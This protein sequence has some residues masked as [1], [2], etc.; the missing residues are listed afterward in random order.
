M[1]VSS[2]ILK[3]KLRE[4]IV[5]DKNTTHNNCRLFQVNETN[6]LVR[7]CTVFVFNFYAATLKKD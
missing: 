5:L 4:W 1:V 6:L 7:N 3:Q 2:G